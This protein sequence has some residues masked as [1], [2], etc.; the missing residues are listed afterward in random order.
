MRH[1]VR[2]AALLVWAAPA[3]AIAAED[4]TIVS[5]ITVGKNAPTTSTQYISTGRVR[6][7]NPETDTIF[8]ASSGRIAV[9]NH[10]KKEYYEFTREEMAAA[11]QQFEAQMQQAGPMM[12]KM[13]GGPMTDVTVRKTGASR[14][15]AGY[16]CDEYTVAMGEALRYDICAAPT[17]TQPA[18]YYD[19]LKTP[20]ASLGPAARRFDKLFEEMKQIKGF[21]V[22][23]SSTVQVM[24]V[25]NQMKTEA[26]EIKKGPIPDSAF[27]IPDGYKKKDSPFKK[28]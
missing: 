28:K 22:S 13:M 11:M 15:V 23:M 9:V 18:Q 25:K 5:T 19:A 26:T 2:I 14:K 3:A 4:L 1:R 6:T 20:F 10:K 7:S 17:L 12:E 24:M 21:P 27:A 16:A 8:D